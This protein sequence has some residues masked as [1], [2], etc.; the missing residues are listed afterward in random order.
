MLDPKEKLIELRSQ[1][2]RALDLENNHETW[3][4]VMTQLFNSAQQVARKADD[5]VKRLQSLLDRAVG[6]KETADMLSDMVIN[7][8]SAH[9]NQRQAQKE[10]IEMQQKG[11]DGPS[12]GDLEMEAIE[13]EAEEKAKALPPTKAEVAPPVSPTPVIPPTPVVTQPQA[14]L[15][16]PPQ[17]MAKTNKAIRKRR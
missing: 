11:L 6:T 16:I 1:L 12:S 7:I 14:K 10:V 17:T 5:E 3:S 15:P 13:K 9:N 8:L 4:G 2:R